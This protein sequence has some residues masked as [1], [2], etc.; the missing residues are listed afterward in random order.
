MKKIIYILLVAISFGF[1]SCDNYFNNYKRTR[2]KID[3]LLSER[4]FE[5]AIEVANNIGGGGLSGEDE[6]VKEELLAN[7][8][9]TQINL[10]MEDG[11]YE[12]ASAIARELKLEDIFYEAFYKQLRQIIKRNRYDFAFETLM[13]WKIPYS[14]QMVVDDYPKYFN[15]GRHEVEKEKKRSGYYDSQECSPGEYNYFIRRINDAVD[16]ILQKVMYEGNPTNIRRCL[17]CYRPYCVYT[18]KNEKIG[19][20]LNEY[21]NDYKHRYFFKM[22]NTAKE[23]AENMLREAKLSIN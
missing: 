3:K 8:S 6:R 10:L 11:E 17:M 21:T 4:R 2:A 1:I 13:D 19:D 18:Q 9:Y 22:Q 20:E 12:T 7:I 15:D 5:E 16:I 14:P 23:E